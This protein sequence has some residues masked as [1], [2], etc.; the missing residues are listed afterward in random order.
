MVK[1]KHVLGN[2]L[3]SSYPKIRNKDDKNL[4]PKMSFFQTLEICFESGMCSESL[5]TT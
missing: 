2:T 1:Q 5:V 3:V 4:T